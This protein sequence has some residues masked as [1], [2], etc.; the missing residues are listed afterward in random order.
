MLSPE[1]EADIA[2]V[3]VH[4]IGQQLRGETL[5]EW[6]EPLHDRLDLLSRET[7]GASIRYS[8][9]LEGD[10]SQVWIDVALA[11]GTRTIR[12]SE[13]RWSESF[14]TF[15]F[16]RVLW[17]A[18]IFTPRII[19]R[20]LKHLF[21]LALSIGR[22]VIA[23]FKIIAMIPKHLFGKRTPEQI[24]QEGHFQ[25]SFGLIIFDGLVIGLF[26][27]FVVALVVSGITTAFAIAVW[28]VVLV[29]VSMVALVIVA[30]LPF[31]GPRVRPV[32][33]AITSTVGD[34]SVWTSSSV[35]AAAM[36]D[37]VRAR[38]QAAAAVSNTVVLLGHSQGAAISAAAVL[39]PDDEKSHVGLLI[40]VGAAVSLLKQPHR[41][42]TPGAVSRWA[43]LPETRWV[44]FWAT[45]DPVPAG[46]IVDSERQ[47]AARWIEAYPVIFDD[48][49]PSAT[50]TTGPA[51]PEEHVVHNRASL[52]FDHGRYSRNIVQV[53]DPIA[54]L[55]LDP[56]ADL[57]DAGD[58]VEVD[59]WRHATSVRQLTSLRVFA[60][61]LGVLAAPTLVQLV[62]PT[63]FFSM[64]WGLV[65]AQGDVAKT[66]AE[67]V[68][69]ASW[70]TSAYVV[71]AVAL[72]YAVV[73]AVGTALLGVVDWSLRRGADPKS[74][75]FGG[76]PLALFRLSVVWAVVFGP[77]VLSEGFVVP[78][79]FLGWFFLSVAVVAT[80]AVY[81]IPWI[82]DLPQRLPARRVGTP[83]SRRKRAGASTGAE[84]S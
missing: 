81:A 51:G 2:L 33:V 14:L 37:V 9:I 64:V 58:K 45:Y 16:E 82:P 47:V 75:W 77:G 63:P 1:D 31:I 11:G 10:E 79:E 34:A 26:L 22:Q 5:L 4:G 48:D 71:A 54:R 61:L 7:G 17:W 67:S 23:V 35:R 44:N 57:V 46:P 52:L 68:Q 84:A 50:A 43:A 19:W 6:V 49:D 28:L 36:R 41:Q 20:V 83:K 70:L 59:N 21:R 15:S 73:V 3:V 42:T 12:F 76:L 65:A 53:V 27:A 39:D 60:V 78:T 72:V 13:A 74:L 56:S 8:S 69:T 32:I 80:A 30:R 25:P 40:T 18:A 66:L 55:L 29:F 24:R 38:V 62:I